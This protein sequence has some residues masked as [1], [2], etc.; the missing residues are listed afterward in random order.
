MKATCQHFRECIEWRKL[1]LAERTR[2]DGTLTKWKFILLRDVF[3]EVETGATRHYNCLGRNGVIWMKIL[4]HGIT[5]M[6]GYAW[7][8]NTGAPETPFGISMLI[9]S[10]VHDGLF[11]F[12]GV[13]GFP[14]LLIS[15]TWCNDLYYALSDKR[16]A[17]AYRIGLALGS[18]AFWG[19]DPEDGEHVESLPLHLTEPT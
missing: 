7:N 9:G 14:R 8:G 13:L 4:P 5:V 17:W 11:Q 18:W 1:T 15:R 2:P 10:L 19:L 12:S 6:K 16:I 3:I